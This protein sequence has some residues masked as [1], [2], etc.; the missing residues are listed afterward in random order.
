MTTITDDM[1]RERISQ[2][3]SYS[4]VILR[5]T[6]KYQEPGMDKIVWEHGRRN[7]QLREAGLL[8]IVCPIADGSDIS[9]V[10]IFNA[11]PEETKKL[12]D[13]D[14]GVKAGIFTFEVHS[15]RGFPGDSL[16]K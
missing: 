10:G 6:E 12:Y 8:S 15:C 14:P 2:T 5:K 16:P 9:G 11:T 4:V 13:D 1:M 7:F 3:K